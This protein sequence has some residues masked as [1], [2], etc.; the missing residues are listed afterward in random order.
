MQQANMCNSILLNIFRAVYICYK[1]VIIVKYEFM[2]KFVKMSKKS[3]LTHLFGKEFITYLNY[4]INSG[5]KY[6]F[7]YKFEP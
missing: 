1:N 6:I 5:L 3:I 4:F 2:I 7:A